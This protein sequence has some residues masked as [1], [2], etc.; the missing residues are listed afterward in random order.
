MIEIEEVLMEEVKIFC[1]R[2]IAIH[3][4]QDGMTLNK[5]CNGNRTIIRF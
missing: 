5:F 3:A 4:I 2:S 1:Y